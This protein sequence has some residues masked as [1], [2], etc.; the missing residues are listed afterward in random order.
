MENSNL[1]WDLLQQSVGAYCGRGVNHEGQ[2]FTGKL[3]LESAIEGKMLAL[4]SSATGDQGE[5][6]HEEASFLGRDLSGALQL[7]VASNNH[8]AIV[9]HAFHRIEE[10][11]GAKSV[12]FRFGHPENRESFR[13]EITIAIHGDGSL[14][15][16]YAWGMPGG[17]FAPRSGS[18]MQKLVHPWQTT[19][20]AWPSEPGAKA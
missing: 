16:H 8:P 5:V 11:D 7:F 20:I 9:A 3:T 12:I 19:S 10:K 4:K 6:F 13:E 17:D 14:T 15:H 2:H 1:A 18:R